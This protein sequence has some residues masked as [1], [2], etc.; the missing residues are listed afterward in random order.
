M[1]LPPQ[2]RASAVDL[3]AMG[4]GNRV[5]LLPGEMAFVRE[6]ST[7]ETLLGS[8]V[9][10]VL[11][12]PARGWGGMNHYMVPA[13]TGNMDAGK[14][15]ELAV[16]KLLQMAALSGCQPSGLKAAILGG[17]AV[18]G[19]LAAA[20]E[21]A[22]LDV[23]R[24]NIACAVQ[25]LMKAGV[26]I[27]KQDIGGTNGRRVKFDSVSG[28]IE[29]KQIASTAEREA[30]SAKLDELRTRKGR[31]LII[32]DSATVRRL[33]RAVIER[34]DDLEV[35]GEAEDPF[36]ARDLLL[37]EDPDALCLD[38]IMPKLDGLSF[39][40]RLMQYKPIPT[41]VVSTIAKAGSQM[42]KNLKDA[43]AIAVIDKDSLAIYQG[44]ET[45]ERSLL[46]A[47]RRAVSAVVQKRVTT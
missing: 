26:T 41:V 28:A 14:V 9:A 40:R 35:C 44:F 39:L 47:L 29:V 16:P 1:T 18:V 12:D 33:L 4:S 27:A 34:S 11:H 5:F 37:Q 32:D 36:Q 31:V 7:I 25:G 23:G 19:H 43:G 24:R 46:P 10:V 3:R 38:V 30:R 20:A 2:T 42:E 13:Q 8:C 17:G 45:A 15:G 22:G 6:P 21:V